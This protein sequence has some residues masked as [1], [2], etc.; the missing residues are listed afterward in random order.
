MYVDRGLWGLPDIRF[1][2]LERFVRWLFTMLAY[3]LTPAGWTLVVGT[4]LCGYLGMISTSI[5]IYHLFAAQLAVW[6]LALLAFLLPRKKIG[7]IFTPPLQARTGQEIRLSLESTPP[8]KVIREVEAICLPLP[9]AMKLLEPS[10]PPQDVMTGEASHFAIHFT[11]R[12]RGFHSIPAPRLISAW[13]LGLLRRTI[14]TGDRFLLKVHPAFTPLAAINLPVGRLHQPGGIIL[15]SHV[16]ESPEYI[17]NRDYRPGD[18]VRHM[19]WRAWART[20][21]PV[22]R[23]FQE[24]YFCRV[25]LILDTFI[26]SGE[27][28]EPGGYPLLEAGIS[29][30][31]A[32]AEIIAR[33]E[34]VIDLFAAGETLHVFRAGRSIAR[35]E[36]VL[37]ILS[38]VEHCHQ[39]GL[40]IITPAIS[41]ELQR[42][43]SVLCIMLGWD[44]ERAGF[45][46]AIT[47]AGCAT[48]VVI[49]HPD[50]SQPPEMTGYSSNQ[51]PLFL[52]PADINSGGV[53]NL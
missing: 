50:G 5:P 26:S 40:D 29:L 36:N 27:K 28:P 38:C 42:L 39:S 2:S 34:H 14:A 45:V 16:G 21:R 8:E 1:P 32:A 24:E 20:A 23:E 46:Q 52:T 35:F 6:T 37:D 22:V 15:S 25:G 41:S 30:A 3:R 19:D 43:T 48:R 11:A 7:L 49:L 4:M 33:E 47:E 51:S 9:V 10:P 44:S 31:A 18:P 17:G 13:P 53:I 12:R